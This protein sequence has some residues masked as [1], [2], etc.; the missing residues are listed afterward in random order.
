MNSYLCESTT[1]SM[2]KRLVRDDPPLN[3]LNCGLVPLNSTSQTHY[4]FYESSGVGTCTGNFYMPSEMAVL[5]KIDLLIVRLDR[6]D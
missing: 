5:G 3:I 1:F 4:G 2:R 6:T